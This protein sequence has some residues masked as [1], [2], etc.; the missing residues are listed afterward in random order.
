MTRK[1]ALGA[2]ATTAILL[3]VLAAASWYSGGLNGYCGETG[4]IASDAAL[5]ESA[6]I[7]EARESD[8]PRAISGAAAAGEYAKDNPDCCAVERWDHPFMTSPFLTVLSG[9]RGFAVTLI[10]PRK[11]PDAD[12]AYQQTTNI[13]DGCGTSIDRYS[14]SSVR[15]PMATQY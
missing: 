8:F 11:H 4:Q 1:L 7:L 2:L 5:I 15:K 10:Y 12:G 14:M 6:L 3:A 9:T 13:I